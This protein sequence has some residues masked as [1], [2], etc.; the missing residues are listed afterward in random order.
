MPYKSRDKQR[1]DFPHQLPRAVKSRDKQ[2]HAAFVV[3]PEIHLPLRSPS[4]GAANRDGAAIQ[5]A[6]RRKE[7]TYPQLVGEGGRARLVTLAGEVGGRWSIETA[8]FLRALAVAK[9]RDATNVLQASVELA[10]FRRWSGILSCAAARA[11]ADSLLEVR[12]AGGAGGDAP[13]S[14]DVVWDNRF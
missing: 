5:A 2:R 6:H 9:A 8:N 14:D 13:S 3:A 1:R 12:V 10:W 7:R 11:F 4:R